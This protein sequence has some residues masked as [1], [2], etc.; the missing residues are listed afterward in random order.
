M[1]LAVKQRLECG[2]D[3]GESKISAV[4]NIHDGEQLHIVLWRLPTPCTLTAELQNDVGR[5]VLARHV[6]K[7]Q[8]ISWRYAFGLSRPSCHFFALTRAVSRRPFSAPRVLTE[9]GLW[10]D[11]ISKKT[12]GQ[13]LCSKLLGF[14]FQLL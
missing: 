13:N 12:L 7:L 11:R 3:F 6:A 4:R 8:A 1:F 14:A 9:E 5:C 10:L 2:D